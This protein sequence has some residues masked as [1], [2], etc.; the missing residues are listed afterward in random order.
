MTVYN[1]LSA[2][3]L[4]QVQILLVSTFFGC[5]ISIGVSNFSEQDD[6]SCVGGCVRQKGPHILVYLS[7][8]YWT[9]VLDLHLEVHSCIR[10]NK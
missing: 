8:P 1:E 4:R 6:E 5:G 7:T 10:M 3:V 9:S 2:R